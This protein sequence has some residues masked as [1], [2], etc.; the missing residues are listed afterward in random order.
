VS[1]YLSNLVAKSLN[2]GELIRPRPV[3]LFEPAGQPGGAY[4]SLAP[5]LVRREDA[6]GADEMAPD[7][8]SEAQPAAE[9]P[10]GSPPAATGLGPPP[11]PESRPPFGPSA[12]PGRRSPPTPAAQPVEIGSQPGAGPPAVGR[13]PQAPAPP[14]SGP[15]VQL[16]RVR[17]PVELTEPVEAGPTPATTQ[18]MAPAGSPGAAQ[19]PSAARGPASLP[20][21]GDDDRQTTRARAGR[22]GR[23]LPAL[24]PVIE[25]IVVEGVVAAPASPGGDDAGQASQTRPSRPAAPAET[26]S[27]LEPVTPPAAPSPAGRASAGVV[28]RPQV[29]LYIEPQAAASLLAPPAGAAPSIRVTIGRVEVRAVPPPARA[30]RKERSG[31][32]VMS[33]DEYLSRRNQGG[34]Q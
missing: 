16:D 7:G 34:G 22:E 13:A 33:L 2:T 1:D 25:K 21:A 27:G 6:P 30:A 31:P 26:A 18:P 29:R 23:P 20:A 28:A 17:P 4:P 10:G 14:E 15:G 12:F 3:S 5:G 24:E 19:G 9:R 8:L 11:R 32:P